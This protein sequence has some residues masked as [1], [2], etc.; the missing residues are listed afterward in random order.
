MIKFS[1]L[2]AGLQSTP[3]QL[4]QTQEAFGTSWNGFV[5]HEIVYVNKS[6]KEV[7]YK[8]FSSL[9]TMN[10]EQ[11]DSRGYSKPERV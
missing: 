11:F 6:D 10:E 1:D 4:N 9:Y 2:K 3:V 5:I 7:V 8:A